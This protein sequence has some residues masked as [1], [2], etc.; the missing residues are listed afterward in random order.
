M[1][2]HAFASTP[3]PSRAA[4]VSILHPRA[5]ASIALASAVAL[6]AAGCGERAEPRRDGATPV[7]SASFRPKS[8]FV[9][10]V[11][12]AGK[13]YHFLVD[14]GASHTA[15]D[16]RLA[17]SITRPSTD[18]QIPIAYRTMLEKGLTTADGVLPRERV[19]LWQPL[20]IALGSYQV[21]SF[22]PW[23]GLD[24]SLLSQVL[25]TQIDGIVG[26]EIFRQ[27]SWVADNRS[28]TLTVWRHPPAAQ[29][30]A[31]CVPYQDSF[32]QSPAVSVDFR[33]R[34]TM[35]RFDTGARYSIASAPTLA[36][37]A[38]HKAAMPLGGTVPSMSANGV[39]ESRDHFV[40]GLSFDSRPVGR[41][42]VAEGG[43]DMLGMNFLARL[44]RYM[45]V[46]STM[47][48]CYDAGRFT[49]DD[50]Q[51]LRTIAIRFV[52]G[53]VELFHNRP[54]DL[55]RYG[56]ENGDVLVEIDGKRVEAPAIDDVRDRL[57]TAPAGS[58]DIVVERGGSRRAVRI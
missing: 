26:I 35:F 5:L 51:P 48:F 14:T 18:E 53:R 47:E 32:G 19:R 10:P 24:L 37:L 52:D 49:Q 38:S 50:P 39:G 56:L 29:R 21:P 9:V 58:L 13:T 8:G 11:S 7:L 28:G 33:D 15:I 25:G 2:R 41:L 54:E 57:S 20:P 43:G 30:F 3:A 34:W 45:F 17:Q 40:S 42:R 55:R 22:Y 36:Y 1:V 4:S 23:L 46:P 16:N 12:I 31:H 6:I 27:L 44:D